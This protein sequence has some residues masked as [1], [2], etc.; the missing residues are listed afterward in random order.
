VKPFDPVLLRARLHSALERKRLQQERRERTQALEKATED[1]QRANDDLQSFATAASHDLQE[2]LRTISTTLQLF[3]LQ[4]GD[5]LSPEQRQLLSL[6][7]EGSKRMSRL[8]S[9][10][11]E[12]SRSGSTEST[13]GN[14]ACEAALR[15]ALTNLR[16]A[17]E[18][19]GA[20]VT[21]GTLPVIVA[22]PGCLVQLFQNLIGNAIKYRSEARPEIRI[23]AQREGPEWVISVGDN[24]IGIAPQFRR[25]VFLPF[26]RLHGPERPGTGL[27]LAI[28][29]RILRN[30]GGRIWVD[31]E[32][33]EGSVFHFTARGPVAENGAAR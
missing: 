8:I 24:G 22:D 33:G 27:G 1:L 31:S 2:P 14:V 30:S 12:Y 4:S 26:G 5:A 11:L 6:A 29:E 16:V 13:L 9:G 23:T 32:P 18:D 25:R 15:E 17:I 21:C 28:C 7:V 3:E 10:L 19:S 20:T